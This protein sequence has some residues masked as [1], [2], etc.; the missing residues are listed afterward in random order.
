MKFSVKGPPPAGFADWLALANADWQPSYADLAGPPMAETRAALLA[1]QG[2]VCAYCGS[3]LGPGYRQSHID[4]FWPQRFFN[5]SAHPDRTLD[6]DN[7]FVSCGPLKE[8]TASSTC[9]AKKADWFDPVDYVIPSHPGCEQRFVYTGAGNIAATAPGDPGA[10]NMMRVLNLNE[11]SLVY[12]RFLI[13]RGLEAAIAEG[14]IT[15]ATK[16]AEIS[17]WRGTD[18]TGRAKSLGQ[19][20]A[21]YIEYERI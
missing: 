11:K 8:K 15:A 7:F 18:E 6:Y 1:E 14:E 5:G 4:H 13:L 3:A 21:R 12:E 17:R 2:H 19:V 16:A 10:E 9:G 20:A